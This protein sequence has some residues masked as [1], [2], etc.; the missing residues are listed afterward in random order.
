MLLTSGGEGRVAHSPKYWYS[1]EM[2]LR[3]LK[4]SAIEGLLS[5]ISLDGT[6]QCFPGKEVDT[7]VVWSRSFWIANWH[8]WSSETGTVKSE[9][10]FTCCSFLIGS[11]VSSVDCWQVL[12]NVK[13]PLSFR[14]LLTSD[15]VPLTGKSSGKIASN[16]IKT[17]SVNTSEY[18]RD[19]IFE[20]RRNMW[21]MID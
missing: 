8:F 1:F 17:L 3:F 6:V 14:R 21:N 4:W 18:M 16:Y 11:A 15:V 12:L 5:H 20:L 10:Y 13:S 2:I 9:T 7:D 19:R